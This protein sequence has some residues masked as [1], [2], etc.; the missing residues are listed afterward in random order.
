MVDHKELHKSLGTSS[1]FHSAETRLPFECGQC[2]G[3][4]IILRD[5]MTTFAYRCLVNNKDVPEATAI[6][7]RPCLRPQRARNEARAPAPGF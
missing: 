3:E 5:S 2:K 4:I 1:I 7:S 6:A